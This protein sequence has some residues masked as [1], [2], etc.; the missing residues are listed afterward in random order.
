[1]DMND[2][3]LAVNVSDLQATQ[4]GPSQPGCIERHQHRAMHQVLSRINRPRDL[5]RTEYGRQLPGAFGK[6]NLI[7]QVGRRRV[8]TKRNRSAAQRLW[9]VPG[10]SFRSRNRC[11]WYSRI[12][13]GPRRSGE[14]WK[15][16]ERSSTAWM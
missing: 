14:R 1:M 10:D 13:V 16:L 8:L 15:Y 4:L 6:R 5:F 9:M 12:W 7:E 2:H 3:A 11:T